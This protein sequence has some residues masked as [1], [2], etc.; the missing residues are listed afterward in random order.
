[1][2]HGVLQCCAQA[3]DMERAMQ[4]SM[5]DLSP[6]PMSELSPIP[7]VD[8]TTTAT[9]DAATPEGGIGPTF[10]SGQRVD[11]DLQKGGVGNGATLAQLRV[12]GQRGGRC[13]HHALHNAILSA[14][15]ATESDDARAAQFLSD[16]MRDVGFWK[17][18]HEH[19]AVLSAESRR[20]ADDIIAQCEGCASSL[21][22]LLLLLR[23][24]RVLGAP[25]C[26]LSGTPPTHSCN[27]QLSTP[28]M[29]QL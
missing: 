24:P 22:L 5:S 7:N 10:G 3:A 15:A 20:R 29:R 23:Q 28:A 26:S 27:V 13:G 2:T 9:T 18:Y 19:T 4:F 21:V 17:R 1:M 25:L 6:I 11:A 12:A 14:S 16:G 8:G